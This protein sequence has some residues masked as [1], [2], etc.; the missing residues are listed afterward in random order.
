LVGC[1]TTA[2]KS[3]VDAV[4]LR[5]Q[6]A[7]SLIEHREWSAAVPP[8]QQGLAMVPNDAELHT[9]LG[10]AYREQGLYE[11][12]EQEFARALALDPRNGDAFGGRALLRE[13]RG[14]GGEAAI[15]DFKNAI[16]HSP[17]NAAH[18]NNYGFALYVRGRYEEAVRVLREGLR[19]AP[20]ARR[21]RN[22]LGFVYGRLGLYNRAR[23]E[24]E[25]GGSLAEAESNLGWIY[26]EAGERG[27]ACE[28]YHEAIRLDPTLAAAA[29]NA[30]HVCPTQSTRRE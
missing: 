30:E 29:A 12:A 17:A 11:A 16:A 15:E 26:E 20:A 4:G 14:D 5:K 25:H 6:L 21:M 9:L 28:R 23:R 8:L 3:R 22:N 24:F 10:V 19:R 2:L 1:A 7:R 13:E 27:L 18:F